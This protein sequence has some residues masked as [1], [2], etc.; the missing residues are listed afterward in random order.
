MLPAL[1]AKGVARVKERAT[2]DEDDVVRASAILALAC[3]GGDDAESRAIVRRATEVGEGVVRGAGAMALLRMDSAQRMED[4]VSGLEAWLG[5]R[6]TILPWFG[7]RFVREVSQQ[8]LLKGPA[9]GLVALARSRGEVRELEALALRLGMKTENGA[10]AR[11]VGQILLELGGFTRFRPNDKYVPFVALVEE[12]TPAERAIAKTLSTTLLLPKAGMGLPA[13]GSCRKTWIGVNPASA[14][15]KVVQYKTA[16]GTKK[17]PLWRAWHDLEADGQYGDPLPDAIDGRLDGFD[18]WHALVEFGS[19][20]HGGGAREMTPE[21][22]E[23]ELARLPTDSSFLGRVA[24]VADDLAARF[25]AAE[26][27]GARMVPT[28]MSS[29]LLFLPLVRAKRPVE[30]RWDPLVRLSDE[31][32]AREVLEALPEDRREALL[33]MW[34]PREEDDNPFFDLDQV[35]SVFDMAPSERIARRIAVH[36]AK[37]DVRAR[38]ADFDSLPRYK[39]KIRLATKKLP[40]LAKVFKGSIKSAPNGSKA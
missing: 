18:R 28:L 19:S 29:G 35:M 34:T 37:K 23:R 9:Q 26:R 22:L 27:E 14:L 11:A 32:P 8:R 6:A 5:H 36:L 16:A 13:A 20:S 1:G 7:G 21:E 10:V 38:L 12:L 33:L 15:D 25:A 4:V 31:P 3:L 30:A 39:E 2:E 17:N 24:E 40:S